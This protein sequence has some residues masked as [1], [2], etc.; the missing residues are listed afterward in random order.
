MVYYF[1]LSIFFMLAVWFLYPIVLFLTSRISD[2]FYSYGYNV[3]PVS[4]I[5]AAHNEED[6]LK[7]RCENIF[8]QDYEADIE[9]IIV[10]DGSND[11]TVSVIQELK[12]QFNNVVFID[13]QPQGGRSNA[14]NMAVQLATHEI[15]IFTDA[16]TVFEN[17]CIAK[18][19][20]PFS[21][22]DVGFVSGTLKYINQNINTISESIGLYW[23][24]EM[25]LRRAESKLGLYA[26]GTGACCAVRKSLYEIIP[27]TGDVDFITPLDVVLKGKKCIHTD[28]AIAWDELPDSPKKEFLAR[29]RMTS[30]NIHGTITRWGFSMIFKKPVYSLTLFFHKIGRWLTPF[31][32]M[33]L[34]I[35][36]LFLL[37]DSWFY[38]AIFLLQILFYSLGFL[39]YLGVRFIF[40]AQIYS[41]LLANIGF[42][43]GV[44]KAMFGKVPYAY[45]PVNKL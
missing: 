25:F 26:T 17:G 28:D 32:L 34:F 42:F 33:S 29:V 20:E 23:K 2:S 12:S 13:V 3:V 41:F 44:L 11:S 10:S 35:S 15:L 24:F 7:K 30:K 4:V 39:G 14:H 6:N 22:V 27:A 16:E 36:N 9:I 31:W 40:S 18:L 8:S 43:F 45:K 21:N 5:I 37:A 19:V 38:F 1:Y